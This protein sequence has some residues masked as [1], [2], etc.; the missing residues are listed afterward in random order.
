MKT[1]L[2]A[3][4]AGEAHLVGDDDHRHPFRG[5]FAHHVEDLLDQLGVEGAGHLVEEHHVRVHRQRPGDR[6]PLLL[7]AGEPFR[8]LVE[9]VGEADPFEQRVAF[10]LA[11]PPRSGRAPFP[12]AMVTFCS[13]VRWGKRLNCWKTIPTRW[14]TKS[15]S[16][17]ASPVPEPRSPAD[18][19][20]LEEDLALLRRLEQVDAAQQ[21]AL[22]GAARAE[23]ADDFAFGDLE[24]D[25]AQHLEV[26]EALVDPLQLEHRLRPSA[27]AD[28]D[29]RRRG[30]RLRLVRA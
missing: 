21:G 22:A 5:Q 18:V 11:P 25:A 3:D 17:P 28:L 29:V 26:A 19:V 10:L 14:R 4:L 13:A 20:A 15:S 12:G 2:V 30:V 27:S 7:A 8:V 16:Q 1:T 6:D 24:V 23:D 9:L